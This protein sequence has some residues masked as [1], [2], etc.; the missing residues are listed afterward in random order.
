MRGNTDVEDCHGVRYHPEHCLIPGHV[1]D[2]KT[3][4][5]RPPS[6]QFR[7]YSAKVTLATATKVLKLSK[8]GK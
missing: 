7:V 4:S 3:S 2:C 8:P 6:F 5:A 1:L